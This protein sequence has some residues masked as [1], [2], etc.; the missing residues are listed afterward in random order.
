MGLAG[1]FIR[2]RG[3]RICESHSRTCLPHDYDDHYS[4]CLLVLLL[5]HYRDLQSIVY[6]LLLHPVSLGH[7]PL[8]EQHPQTGPD[9][10]VGHTVLRK[11]SS[12]TI[13]SRPLAPARP[14]L[15]LPNSAACR[16]QRITQ[17]TPSPGASPPPKASAFPNTPTNPPL[18]HQKKRTK[19][20]PYRPYT[21]PQSAKAL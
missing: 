21:R 20:R 2:W 12:A 10:H 7:A 14:L 3:L 9:R 6:V 19:L 1:G 5:Q 13:L 17:A 8:S 18:P 4:S 15:N 16:S 11:N